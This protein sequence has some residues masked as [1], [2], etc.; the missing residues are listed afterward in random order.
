MMTSIVSVA[1]LVFALALCVVPCCRNFMDH[2]GVSERL[3]KATGW[4]DLLQPSA[5]RE[6]ME[7]GSDEAS[8]LSNITYIHSH[9]YIIEYEFQ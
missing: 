1:S 9:T 7:Q 8:W 4:R 5:S 3:N 2:Q 6:Y